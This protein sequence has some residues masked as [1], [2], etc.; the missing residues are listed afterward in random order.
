MLRKI[1]RHKQDALIGPDRLGVS[2]ARAFQITGSD[3]PCVNEDKNEDT[4]K[5]ILPG[6]R[7]I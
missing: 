1:R 2:S 3:Q 5:I 4:G 6:T 7:N